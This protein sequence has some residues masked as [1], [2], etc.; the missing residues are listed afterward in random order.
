M[1]KLTRGTDGDDRWY[2]ELT[3]NS[4]VHTINDWEQLIRRKGIKWNWYS[5]HFIHIYFENDTNFAQGVE[6]EFVILGLGFRFRYNRKEFNEKCKEWDE[7][8]QNK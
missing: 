1:I 6:F 3:P 5:F 8:N 7:E 2:L 4:F